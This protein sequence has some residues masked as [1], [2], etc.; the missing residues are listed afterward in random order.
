M[1]QKCQ[2]KVQEGFEKGFGV[3]AD[4]VSKRTTIVFIASLIIFLGFGK[5]ISLS[6]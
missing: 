5:L 3:W 6:L 2:K 1:S 4:M